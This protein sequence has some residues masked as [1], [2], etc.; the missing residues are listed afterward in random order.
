M[1]TT[2]IQLQKGFTLI[3]LMITIAIIGILA[4]IAIPSYQNYT[5]KAAY[6]EVVNQTA[7]YKISVMECY[8]LTGGLGECNA[9]KNGIPANISQG[10]HLINSLNVE[11]GKISIIPN[12]QKGITSDDTYILT[13]ELPNETHHSVIWQTSGG[14]VDK[15]YVK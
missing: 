9:G 14:G 13:P 5:R 4:T 2:A 6:S 12:N 11:N 10:T 3:E 15:G 1:Q 8:H 7:S